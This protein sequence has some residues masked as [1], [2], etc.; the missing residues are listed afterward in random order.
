MLKKR[1]RAAPRVVQAPAP[2]LMPSAPLPTNRV[3]SVVLRP[4]EDV[5]WI[6]ASSA[7]GGSYVSGFV[8]HQLK[9]TI[10]DKMR[11]KKS[12]RHRPRPVD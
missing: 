6:W 11:P 4:G 5:E 3:M 1:I 8:I 7:D 10:L 2:A 9:G 12:R